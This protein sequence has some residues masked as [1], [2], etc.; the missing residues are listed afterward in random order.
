MNFVSTLSGKPADTTAN[1]NGYGLYIENECHSGGVTIDRG[2]IEQGAGPAIYVKNVNGTDMP[3]TI[4]KIW[5]ENPSPSD[6]VVLDAT[7]C[8]VLQKCRITG[9]EEGQADIRAIRLKNDAYNNVISENMIAVAGDPLPATGYSKGDQIELETGCVNNRIE[10][11]VTLHSNLAIGGGVPVIASGRNHVLGQWQV[12]SYAD[13]APT[14]SQWQ[15]GDIVFN[16]RPD[17]FHFVG[18]VC[19]EAGTP[20]SWRRFGEI[21]P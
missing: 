1:P 13:T 16:T 5:I 19:V 17:Q 8:V 2:D 11:N 18:W 7:R 21:G 6:T 14:S 10:N 12:I 9:G 20:G 3:T 4:Q 15:R